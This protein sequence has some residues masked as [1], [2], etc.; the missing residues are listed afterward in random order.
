MKKKFKFIVG[1]LSLL[2][3]TLIFSPK[4]FNL[5]NLFHHH[6]FL[7]QQMTKKSSL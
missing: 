6:L 2:S 4:N 3:V 7:L 1:S 5:K